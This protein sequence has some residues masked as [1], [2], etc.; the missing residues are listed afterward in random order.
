MPSLTD[1]EWLG[2]PAILLQAPGNALP[3]AGTRGIGGRSPTRTP[4]NTTV[5]KESPG[6]AARD[7]WIGRP[8]AMRAARYSRY[9][10]K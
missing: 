1:R 5:W 10:A 6:G 7:G 4:E 8:P 2:E 3:G 9:A